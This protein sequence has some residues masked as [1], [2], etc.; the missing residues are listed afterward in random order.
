MKLLATSL[1]L[2]TISFLVSL[3]FIIRTTFFKKISKIKIP[4][5][6]DF[7]LMDFDR[8]VTIE[9]LYIEGFLD[10]ITQQVLVHSKLLF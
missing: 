1:T 6:V 4:A 3:I 7:L 8:K 2:L 9:L 10:G 5:I